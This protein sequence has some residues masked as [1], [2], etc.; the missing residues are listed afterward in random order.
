MYEELSLL[1]K[2]PRV[3]KLAPPHAEPTAKDVHI[4]FKR[5]IDVSDTTLSLPV[6]CKHKEE[7]EEEEEMAHQNY[8]Y[9]N[10]EDDFSI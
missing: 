6:E 2:S 5:T 9:A 8:L 10:I 7:K 4:D 3:Q 1:L